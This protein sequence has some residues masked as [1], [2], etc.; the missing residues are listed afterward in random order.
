MGGRI[1]ESAETFH[2]A[3]SG[4]GSTWAFEVASRIAR[5]AGSLLLSANGI[6][7]R[8]GSRMVLEPCELELRAGE[9]VALVGPNGAGKSTLLSILA[10]A[11]D[12]STGT[13]ECAVDVGWA[14]QRPALYGKLTPRENL[15]L[16]ADLARVPATVAALP[17]RPAGELSVG[18]RQRLNLELALLGAPRILLL[19][20]PTAALDSERRGELW[21][22][23]DRLR[24]A[25]GAV[26]FAT[27]NLDEIGRGDRVARIED[28]RL[29]VE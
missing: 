10:G 9:T 20:E 6:S 27:Q 16:F 19:D 29:T 14:P 26:C 12:P 5:M 21:A 18:Q 17:E 25:G 24:G 28:G 3:G 7:R 13:V 1:A 22:E 8:F 4:D 2:R 11:L 23:L 15:Q